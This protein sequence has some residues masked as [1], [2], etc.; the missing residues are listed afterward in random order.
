MR[1]SDAQLA[2]AVEQLKSGGVLGLPT[3]TVY[4]LA[5]DGTNPE[6]VRKI[7]AIKGRPADHP[8]IL[9]LAEAAWMERYARNVPPV[10]HTLAA[11]FWP[12]PMSLVLERGADVPDEVTGGLSTVAVRVP[13]HPIARQVMAALGRPLAAP[14]AN[15]F[16]EVSPTT[17]EHVVRD[18]G[19]QVPLVLDGG[20]CEVG[21]ESTI[22]DLTRGAPRVLRPGGV[23]EAM[24]EAALRAPVAANEGPAPA[25][26]GT[27]D[28]H[29]APRAEVRI[30]A[31]DALWDAVRAAGPGLAVGVFA[32]ERPP[33]ELRAQVQYRASGDARQAAHELYAALRS[34]DDAGCDVIFAVCPEEVGVGRAVADRLRRAAVGSRR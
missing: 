22:I 10:A 6:A 30:V 7:F 33:R 3:E 34:L 15:R 18:F 16:G 17:R 8:L 2:E 23:T 27:L 12:G 4:G 5:A 21:V 28:A 26:P 1:L 20:P 32:A 11:A 25:A 13:S 19:D 31:A 29:Y 14:S 24:I 9:H